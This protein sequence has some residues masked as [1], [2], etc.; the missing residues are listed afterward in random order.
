MSYKDYDIDDDLEDE[1]DDDEPAVYEYKI[2]GVTFANDDGTNR[3]ELLRKI[4][5]KEAPFKGFINYSLREYSYEGK[6]AVA[7]LANGITIGNVP[8]ENAEN[9]AKHMQYISNVFVRVFGGEDGKKYGA[10]VRLTVTPP[11]IDVEKLIANR[12]AAS[13]PPSAPQ[14]RRNQL[15]EGLAEWIKK[16]INRFLLLALIVLLL[17]ILLISYKAT[18][19]PKDLVGLWQ[20]ES[21][22]SSEQANDRLDLSYETLCA[23]AQV[24][25]KLNN[26]T[27]KQIEYI[28]EAGSYSAGL[29]SPDNGVVRYTFN[30]DAPD[31]KAKNLDVT[32]DSALVTDESVK[33]VGDAFDQLLR[34]LDSDA[35]MNVGFSKIYKELSSS[36]ESNGIRGEYFTN[37]LEFNYW[38]INDNIVITIYPK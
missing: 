19:K 36:Y 27:Y 9:I 15:R 23:I 12:R 29:Y 6:T 3:Q 34:F 16:P 32:I 30:S 5:G 21:N 31:S 17:V 4:K 7:V 33:I 2:V 8:K 22:V 11:R 35:Y 37:K 13:T 10:I 18:H 1:D 28:N 24:V 26:I 14:K 20:Y 25:G 38:V